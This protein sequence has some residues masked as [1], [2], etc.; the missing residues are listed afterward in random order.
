MKKLFTLK[1][2]ITLEF[3]KSGTGQPMVFL[4]GFTFDKRIFHQVTEKLNTKFTIYNVNLPGVM[5]SEKPGDYSFENQADI[6]ID[7]IRT[8]NIRQPV[9][10]GHSMG[11]YI[12]LEILRKNEE[13]LGGFCL[14]HSHPF[15]DSAQKKKERAK[16]IEFI[17]QYGTALLMKK[18]IPDL[19]S[20]IYAKTN[21]FLIDTLIQVAARI[22]QDV[23]AGQ[24]RAMIDRNDHA[25]TLKN[26]GIPVLTI[27]GKQDTAIPEDYWKEAAL[28]PKISKL[29]AID[30]CVHMAMYEH[31][32]QVVKELADF[33]A[34]CKNI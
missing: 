9:L 2:E 5:Q 10:I 4:H 23:I 6:I 25:D 22:P 21:V 7:F 27:A 30:N 3:E 26:A 15:R 12:G 1:K 32:V 31:T 8:Q 29:V 33:A 24:L 34:T 16:S 13:L 18:M 19:F 11:G 17:S 14:F 20:E 28:L